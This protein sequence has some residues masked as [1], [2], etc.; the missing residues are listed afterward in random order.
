MTICTPFG[1]INNEWDVATQN[2]FENSQH[3]GCYKRY[4]IAA[5]LTLAKPSTCV[6]LPSQ[7]ACCVEFQAGYFPKHSLHHCKATRRCDPLKVDAGISN[8]VGGPIS[9]WSPIPH[10]TSVPISVSFLALTML[11]IFLVPM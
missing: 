6:G 2:P 5:I 9:A 8:K 4:K 11:L 3:F 1:K 7:S 10:P